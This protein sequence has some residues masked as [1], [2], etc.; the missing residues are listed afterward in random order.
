MGANDARFFRGRAVI[1]TLLSYHC[2]DAVPV[3]TQGSV[4][5]LW[6]VG[7]KERLR[8]KDGHTVVPDCYARGSPVYKSR[9]NQAFSS[10]GGT[11]LEKCISATGRSRRRE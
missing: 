10:L 7:T 2:N 6:R 8:Y 4:R 11:P 3:R 1:R 5:F 9:R